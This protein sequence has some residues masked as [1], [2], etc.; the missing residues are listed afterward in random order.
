MVWTYVCNRLE[1][2]QFT[3][4]GGFSGGLAVFQLRQRLRHVCLV[5]TA[6]GGWLRRGFGFLFGALGR[7]FGKHWNFVWE[8]VFFNS[9]LWIFVGTLGI[10]CVPKR[11]IGQRMFLENPGDLQK[12]GRG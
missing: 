6:P 11:K 12:T 4:G 1:N 8:N 9:N 2:G 10:F 5:A 3:S 7:F